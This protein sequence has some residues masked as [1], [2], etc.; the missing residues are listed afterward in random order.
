MHAKLGL[1]GSVAGHD[2]IG[3]LL[4]L[5]G[6]QRVDYTKCLRALSSVMRGDAEPARALFTEPGPFDAWTIGWLG[7][8][9]DERA[10]IAD[11]MD[12]VNPIYVPR[13]HIVEEVLTAA[14]WGDQGAL[15]EL[16]DA[17]THPFE[18]R[19]G[20]ER[21]AEPAPDA[22]GYRTFCGT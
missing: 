7:L 21:Y 10:A 20:L 15:G 5:M 18:Q 16:L 2:I 19:P 17:V 22:S 14:S 3:D 11:R 13:N 8:V 1:D 6:E 4:A 9:G 12:R